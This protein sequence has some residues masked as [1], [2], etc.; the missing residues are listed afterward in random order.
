MA[1]TGNYL[2]KLKKEL[3]KN[4]NKDTLLDST[5]FRNTIGSRVGVDPHKFGLII[6]DIDNKFKDR[7]TEYTSSV[8]YILDER[9]SRKHK[10]F[11][12]IPFQYIEQI[13]VWS[14]T[15]NYAEAGDVMG[16]FE[17]QALYSNSAAQDITISLQ[18]YAETSEEHSYNSG[19]DD[20]TLDAIERYAFQLKSLVFPQYDGGFSPPCKVLFNLG[21][22]FVDVPLVVKSVTVEDQNPLDLATMRSM[23]KKITL[24]CK[25]SYPSW[26]AISAVQVWTADSGAVFGKQDFKKLS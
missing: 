2:R 17:S 24:E 22:M 15:A 4:W 20:W 14:K 16:R 26:Q 21:N 12:G 10:R 8:R 18:Y 9:T 6:W 7:M 3:D 19:E 13:P 11:F 25:T 5:N 1:N 23:L